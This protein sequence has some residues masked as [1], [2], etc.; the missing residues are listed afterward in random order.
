MWPKRAASRYTT[1]VMRAAVHSGRSDVVLHLLRLGEPPDHPDGRQSHLSSAIATR[2]RV[3]AEILLFAGASLDLALR[4]SLRSVAHLFERPADPNYWC[5]DMLLSALDVKRLYARGVPILSMAVSSPA[6]IRHLIARG[7]DPN[8]RDARSFPRGEDCVLLT[9][10]REGHA[11]SALTLLSLGASPFWTSPPPSTPL[12][13]F[14]CKSDALVSV[15]KELLCRGVPYNTSELLSTAALKLSV[16]NVTLLL[17]CGASTQDLNGALIRACAF[18]PREVAMAEAQLRVT[19]LLV[20]HGAQV[21]VDFLVLRAPSTWPP[22]VALLMVACVEAS[23]ED[24]RQLAWS[25]GAKT[26]EEETLLAE[27]RAACPL[28]TTKLP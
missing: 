16:A 28:R 23:R 26:G 17:D 25:M 24:L 12:V 9:A 15:T 18:F 4:Q 14:S 8:E 2:D 5:I 13:H 7:A 11:E 10:M 22:L 6:L 19:E 27:V 21:R 20:L 1:Q 3:T